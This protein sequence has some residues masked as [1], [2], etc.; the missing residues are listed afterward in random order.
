MK[1]YCCLL[2]SASCVCWSSQGFWVL[3]SLADVSYKRHLF[4]NACY[5]GQHASDTSRLF[6]GAFAW[7]MLGSPFLSFPRWQGVSRAVLY[8]LLHPPSGLQR[9]RTYLSVLKLDQ[10]PILN[11]Y[12]HV[13]ISV[14]FRY[15]P[16]EVCVCGFVCLFCVFC[17]CVLGLFFF[18]LLL[19]AQIGQDKSRAHWWGCVSSEL[20]VLAVLLACCMCQMG[21]LSAKL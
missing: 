7:L 13:W 16:S 15:D 17:V 10:S 3:P 21:H 5:C 19:K 9:R 2:R 4:K 14:R 12:E 8:Q 18:F 1:P 20:L 11:L 6:W